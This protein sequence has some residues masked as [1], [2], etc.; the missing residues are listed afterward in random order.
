MTNSKTASGSAL[1]A[2]FGKPPLLS[3][4]DEAAFQ[5]LSDEFRKAMSPKDFVEEILI[6]DAIDLT[7]EIQRLKDYKRQIIQANR[8]D[9]LKKS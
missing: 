2:I 9:A 7:W 6:R 1:N 8:E 4:E 5:R 3:G